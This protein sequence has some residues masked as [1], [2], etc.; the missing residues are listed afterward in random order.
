M[1][2]MLLQTSLHHESD[3]VPFG[4]QQLS[5]TRS[6]NIEQLPVSDLLDKQ[7]WRLL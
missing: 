3:T 2:E 5:A 4:T 1:Y 7:R 6:T